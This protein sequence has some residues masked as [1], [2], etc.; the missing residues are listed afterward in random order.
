MHR[1]AFLLCLILSTPLAAQ[2]PSRL[3]L[4][5]EVR[6][7]P[8]PSTAVTMLNVGRDTPVSVGELLRLDRWTLE[9]K[10]ALPHR[11]Y[12]EL[13]EVVRAAGLDL[14][15]TAAEINF[16]VRHGRLP[17]IGPES[18]VDRL[19]LS[20][21]ARSLL[22]RQGVELVGQTGTLCR[23]TIARA[24]I[25]ARVPNEI[26]AV[27]APFG[28]MLWS[29]EAELA[30]ARRGRLTAAAVPLSSVR[31]GRGLPKILR[32]L[33][34]W[35]I[36]ELKRADRTR[37]LFAAE[38]MQAGTRRNLAAV[39]A[40]FGHAAAWMHAV[41]DLGLPPEVARILRERKILTRRDLMVLMNEPERLGR[42]GLGGEDL[43]RIRVTLGHRACG[44][45]LEVVDVQA[46]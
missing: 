15:L 23:E 39:L 20:F 4:K 21:A 46:E 9:H 25:P 1:S 11:A 43:N 3:R 28:F 44:T 37:D 7:P 18:R 40:R 10:M 30:L 27:V 32:D 35:S 5:H 33:D 36:E 19:E 8:F 45:L 2:T 22:R 24:G 16:F 38:G 17:P 42:V 12:L 14:H 41:A 31:L 29:T 26:A 34:I 13:R 6:T